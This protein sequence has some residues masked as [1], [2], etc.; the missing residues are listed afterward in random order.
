VAGGV[1]TGVNGGRLRGYR[2]AG[3]RPAQPH[4]KEPPTPTSAGGPLAAPPIPNLRDIGGCAT[5]SGA[6]VR[7]GLLYRSSGLH[8]LTPAGSDALAR[9]AVRT[10]YDLRVAR[11]Q[12]EAPD[13]LPAG[14]RH[15][16]L[17]VLAAW[18]EDGPS[19]LFAWAS[20]PAAAHDALEGGGAEALWVEQYRALVR[21]PSA[22]TGYG[23]LFRDL[24]VASHRPA[25]A[26]CVTGKDRTGWVAAA[27]QVLLG[28]PE[29]AVMDHFLESRHHLGPLVEPLLAAIAARGG[30][31]ELFRPALEVR[32][33][34]LEAALD[35]VR[36]TY[37]TMERY[38]S[39]GLGVDEATQEALRAA[40]TG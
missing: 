2:Q 23:A 38:F 29:D 25:L 7:T 20:D 11:E 31:P 37:G 17:D 6:R 1:P 26:H 15:L 10:V 16:P 24:A 4:T 9:L 22:R 13:R 33:G 35:E 5:R 18:A 19:R 34:Y 27:L 40:F 36:A 30:D 14:T 39:D 3:P 32:P 8:A 21:L 28:V 12:A